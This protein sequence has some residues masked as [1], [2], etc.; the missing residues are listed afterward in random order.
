MEQVQ[1][2]VHKQK[3][4]MQKKETMWGVLFILP[5]FLDFCFLS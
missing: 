2:L 5:G 1:N 4:R 3:R